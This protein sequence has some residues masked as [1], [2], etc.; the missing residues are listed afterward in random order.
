MIFETVILLLLGFGLGVIW[1]T[2]RMASDIAELKE[3]CLAAQQEEEE[4]NEMLLRVEE[5]H[6]IICV[7]EKDSDNFVAQGANVT[8]L[9]E[10]F[11]TRFPGRSANVVDGPDEV[12]GRLREQ[13]EI[14]KKSTD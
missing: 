8:E 3:R 5:N 4:S 6:G 13:N 11:R 2:Y 14:R 1:T 12:L 9:F 7:Y 10:H